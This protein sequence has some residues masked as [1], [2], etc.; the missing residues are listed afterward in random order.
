[1]CVCVCVCLDESDSETHFLPLP[2]LKPTALPVQNTPPPAHTLTATHVQHVHTHTRAHTH[3]HTR[4]HR[5]Q[6]L[7]EREEAALAECT[8]KPTVSKGTARRSASTGRAP[9]HMRVADELRSRN[10]R[11]TNVRI[12]M[13]SGVPVCVCVC[14]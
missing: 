5:G 12:R 7:R 2:S 4:T 11:L 14:V 3:I 1:M 8:F 9:L 6:L 13:V 10:E